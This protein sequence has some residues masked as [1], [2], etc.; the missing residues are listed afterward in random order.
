MVVSVSPGGLVGPACWVHLSQQPCGTGN[1]SHRLLT[2]Q[3]LATATVLRQQLPSTPSRR[4]SKQSCAWAFLREVPIPIS[5]EILEQFCAPG[6][7]TT[8][9]F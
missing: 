5:S 9:P 8:W 1:F 6:P 2:T 4:P 3:L 7:A